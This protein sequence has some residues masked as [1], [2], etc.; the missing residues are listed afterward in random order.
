MSPDGFEGDFSGG[1]IAV[2]GSNGRMGRM[3]CNRFRAAGY[4]VAELDQP[5]TNT[6]LSA[7]LSGA[8]VVLLCIPAAAFVT[9]LQQISGI[10]QPPQVL[11][12]ITSVKVQPMHQMQ[13][14]YNG[15][16]VGT[17]PLFGPEPKADEV[18]VAVTPAEGTDEKHAAM[19]EELFERIG[20]EPFR[21][22]AE[23]HDE[24]A[25]LIQGLNFITTVSYLATLAHKEEITPYLTPSFQRRLDAAKKMMTEDAE[26]FEGLFEANPSSHNAVRSFRNMLNIAAGGDINVLVERA[27]WWWRENNDTGGVRH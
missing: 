6:S 13:L 11:V 20:C 27:L 5:L 14:A 7:G 25:A 4:E 15:P 1:K 12:D 18:R 19:V 17:H 21:T 26:L 16:I 10:L 23:A 3:L 9:V 24:A 2:I 8:S 22:T